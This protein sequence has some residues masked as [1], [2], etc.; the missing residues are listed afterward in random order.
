MSKTFLNNRLLFLI[1]VSKRSI[2]IQPK[3]DLGIKMKSLNDKKQFKETIQLFDKYK[4][5]HIKDFSSLIIT[6]ALK[7]CSQLKYLEYGLNIH[8]H[9]PSHL[10][11]NAYILSSLIHLYSKFYIEMFMYISLF[12][13]I[14]SAM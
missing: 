7:A 9:L 6:Q 3:F 14:S 13:Y 11:D 10:K 2:S 12:F 8:H 1:A 4:G 5:D